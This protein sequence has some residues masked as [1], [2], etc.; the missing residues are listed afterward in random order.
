MLTRSQHHSALRIRW[1]ASAVLI[2]SLTAI[3]LLSGLGAYVLH[4][5]GS[6]GLVRSQPRQ[7]GH[8]S[9]TGKSAPQHIT[10]TVESAHPGEQFALGAVGL[11]IETKALST[12]D[13]G[14][15]H[16]QLVKLMR[17]LG[18][19]VLRIGG[20]SL[21]DSW[22][23]S[24]DEAPPAWATSAIAPSD[25]IALR[26]LL[27]ATHWRAILGVDLGHS[28]PAR[29]A[30]QTQAAEEILGSRLLGIEIGNEPNGYMTPSINLRSDTYN[31]N[32]YLREVSV[33]SAAVH[34]VAPTVALYGPD[35][36]TPNNWMT[37]IASDP[38]S[39]FAVLTEHYY[40]TR[41]SVAQGA[42]E[43]THI[44]TALELLSP[45]V[46]QEE[47]E[48]L[49]LLVTDGQ[50]AHRPIRVSETNTTAS[51]DA[52]GGPDTG[53][54]FAS[55]LW[56]LDWVLRAASAGVTG[57]NFQGSFGH[58]AP[59]A[60]TPICEPNSAKGARGA[61]LPRPEYYGLLA[62]RQLE[63]GRFVPIDISEPSAS[64]NLTAYATVHPNG[65]M[66]L[67]I[68]NFGTNGS[69]RLLVK[70]LGYD[71]ATSKLLVGPSVNATS[72]V[73]F[74][75][76]K[77][78]SAKEPAGQ[79]LSQTAGAFQLKIAPTSAVVLNLD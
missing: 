79:G 42:C 35:L 67:A 77:T 64:T 48:V 63:G 22:W 45:Q 47:N 3:L 43:G 38:Q 31:V 24:D 57:L 8:L 76:S 7:F 10:L 62:A 19:G 15:G 16:G 55:A 39:P 68:D 11:S 28:E 52:S 71:K 53:P 56:S 21:D 14:T 50:I 72:G 70:A 1:T 9:R 59:D 41:Y 65:V 74:A 78:T 12:Q 32:E 73:T 58:C 4:H 44:P 2:S 36:S 54:V 20:N 17:L 46:R 26:N 75:R 23:T 66:T 34:A 5:T 49:K 25:L 40:P 69:I 37:T 60:F 33:Y 29:A 27:V 30:G 51:C 61:T 18:P 13:L 6:T